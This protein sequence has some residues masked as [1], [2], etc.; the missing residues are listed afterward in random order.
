MP[1]IATV[2]REEIR[3]L[4]RKEAKTVIDS[5]RKVTAQ[6]RRDIAELKRTVFALQ[7]EV[8]LL[9]K[10][11]AK[12][13]GKVQAPNGPIEGT[14]FSSKSVRAQRKRLGLSRNDF[15]RLLGVSPQSVYNWENDEARP[16]DEAM[17]ALVA[18]RKLGKR[19]A[20]RRLEMM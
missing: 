17:A 6:H 16:R 9:R 14:R 12:R 20:E 13:G 18:V 2:L 7:K 3:R 19:E 15:G 1:N 10:T 11:E 8:A 5:T 4:A